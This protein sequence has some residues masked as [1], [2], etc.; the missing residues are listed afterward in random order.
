MPPL[1][2]LQ[3]ISKSYGSRTLFSDLS[4][5]IE[6]GERIGL[7]GPN[8]AGKSTLLKIM[9]GQ[10]E[11]EEGD[12]SVQRSLRI[13]YLQQLPSFGQGATV[14]SSILEGSAHSD[15]GS[16][17]TLAYELISK[18]GLDGGEKV[19]PETPVAS[20]SG[21]WKKRVALARELMREPDLLLLDEPTNHLDV[22]SILW[23]EGFLQRAPFASVTITHD[24]YFLQKVASRIWELDR[25]N[26]GG[27]LSVKGGYAD[28][29]DAKQELLANQAKLE[30][31]LRNTLRREQEWLRA[32]VKARG[33]KQQARI[34]RAGELAEQVSEIKS[35]NATRNAGIEFSAEG[36]HPKK[37]LEA[38]GLSKSLGPRCLFKDLGL[39]VSPG[40]RIALLGP[41]GCGKSTLLRVLLGQQAPDAGQVFHSDHLKVA[42]FEQNRE[43]LDPA[44]SLIHAIAPHGDQVIYR[45]NPVHVRGYLDRF[46]FSPAQMNM[47]V[48]QLSGGE[49]SRLLIARLM[50]EEANVLVLDEPTNDLDLETLAILEDCLTGFEG[51]VLLVTHDRFFL[52]RVST[53]ILAFHP[54]GNGAIE[55]FASLSQWESWHEE[56]VKKVES[57][58]WKPSVAPAA[59]PSV[60]K[61]KL[62]YKEQRELEGMEDSIQNAEAE[63]SRLEAELQIPEVAVN[64]LK[65]TELTQSIALLH[66]KRERLYAR[67]EELEKLKCPS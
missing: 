51:A 52:D 46:L 5:A 26:P 43:A 34:Q 12:K 33:T 53:Q 8:G 17:L 58:E 13:G 45:G 44:Q 65:L 9:A 16:T 66:E 42:Y 20:L 22:E 29:L 35:R 49:Q 48:G 47:S 27:L 19:S 59:P 63:L 21:G 31:S 28:Y 24:R 40:S 32:G 14:L 11:A 2:S 39:L 15:E 60:A 41:N 30:Q 18:L 67:W 64:A 62:S 56:E 54:A 25:R 7:I 37:L 50:L 6:A 3:S 38:K 23:M 10:L 61:K 1:L 55:S 4:V 36:H 57:K